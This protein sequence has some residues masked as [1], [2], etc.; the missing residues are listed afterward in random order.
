ML[1]STFTAVLFHAE[2]CN[3]EH[4]HPALQ[5]LTE[6]RQDAHREHYQLAPEICCPE[7]VALINERIA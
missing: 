6:K 2:E 1:H 5:S 4:V 7:I 3:A